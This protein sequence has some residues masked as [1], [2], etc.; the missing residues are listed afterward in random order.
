MANADG[1]EVTSY[2][3][4]HRRDLLLS[5]VAPLLLV[6]VALLQVYRVNTLDQSS[7]SGAGFGMFATIDNETYRLI[8]GYVVEPAGEQRVVLPGELTRQAFEVRVVPTDSRV[9]ALAE[10]WRERAAVGDQPFAVEVWT[11]DFDSDTPS[12][13]ATAHTRMVVE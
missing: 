6:C 1:C 4:E 8:R 2:L 5:V 3:A 10:A 13:T 11:L 7:W 12:L 9:R